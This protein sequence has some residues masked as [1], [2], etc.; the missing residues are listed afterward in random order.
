MGDEDQAQCEHEGCRQV[1]AGLVECRTVVY[2]NYDMPWY[3][4]IQIAGWRQGL[5]HIREMKRRGYT[6]LMNTYCVDH[7]QEEGFCF[8]CGEF[9]AGCESFDFNPSGLCSNCHHQFEDEVWDEVGYD[10]FPDEWGWD[11]YDI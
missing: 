5:R 4:F 1:D 8:G 7:C 2:S 3:W 11:Y 9:W 6:E 10:A